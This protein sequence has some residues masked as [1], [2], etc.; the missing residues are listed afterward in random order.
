MKRISIF[1]GKNRFSELVANAAKGEPHVITKN[2]RETAVVIS[3]EEYK[4]LKVK[5]KPLVDL[6]LDNPA[7]KYGIEI[8]LE[9]S[10]DMGRATP[11]FSDE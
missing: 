3:I 5:E 6:L 4:R 1:E 2:G 9:R 7:H 11:D 8:D 10:R